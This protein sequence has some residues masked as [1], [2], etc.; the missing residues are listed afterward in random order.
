VFYYTQ[1]MQLAHFPVSWTDI[2]DPD[3]FVEVSQGRAAARVED[4]LRLAQLVEDLKALAVK[5]IKP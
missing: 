1:D 5:E 3:P 2:A 4:L